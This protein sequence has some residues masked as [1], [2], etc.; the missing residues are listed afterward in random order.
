ME[1]FITPAGYILFGIIVV[2][3]LSIA[4]YLRTGENPIKWMVWDFTG[5]HFIWRKILPP[6]T[7]ESEKKNVPTFMLWIVGIYV[8][9]FGIASQRYENRVDIIENRANAIFAQLG[10]DVKDKALG[11]I[12]RVQNMACPTKP[13]ILNPRSLFLSLFGNN[14]KY[15]QM[16]QD[17][18]ETVEDWKAHLKGVDLAKADLMG[19]NLQEANLEGTIL[20]LVNLKKANL[21]GANLQSASFMKANLEQA[22]LWLALLRKADFKRANLK[23]TKLGGAELGWVNFDGSNLEGA[24]LQMANLEQAINLTVEQLSKAKT[25]YRAKL[26]P[27]LEAEIKEKYP[28]LLEEPKP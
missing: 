26:D 5:L 8:A 2:F 7:P 3:F 25:L 10:T 23:A 9:L 13:E 12:A 4:N 20:T 11:R 1:S 22:Q 19:V 16:I 18:K 15:Y 21:R 24:D 14:D 17:L 6:N 28:R 27:E